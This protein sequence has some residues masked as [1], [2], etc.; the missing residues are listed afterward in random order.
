LLPNQE[1]VSGAWLIHHSSK[2]QNVSTSIEYENI[3]A[4]GKSATLLSALSAESEIT[5]PH[6]RVRTLAVAARISSLELPSILGIL[7]KRSLID[8]GSEEI[9]V[10]GLTTRAT[11]SHASDIFESRT[12]NNIERASLLLAEISSHSPVD[13][14]SIAERLGDEFSLSAYEVGQ[15]LNDAEQIG[16]VDVE[17]LDNQEQLYF[18]G[19]LFRRESISKA[20][21]V[22]DSLTRAEEVAVQEL[23]QE[24]QATACLSLDRVTTV[25]GDNLFGKVFAIGLFDMNTVCNS[26]E[27]VAFIT[28]PSSF[29]KYSSSM[30]DDAFDLAKA[31]VC[32]I[33]YGMT[34]S[35]HVRGRISMVSRLLEVLIR[36]QEVGPVQAIA[37]DY[38]LLELKGVVSVRIGSRNGRH[39]PILRLLKPEV[40]ELALQVIQ[41][42]DASEHSLLSLPTAKVTSFRGPEHN[43]EIIRKKQRELN[44][45]VTNDML[46]ALRRGRIF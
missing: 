38:R 44:P 7:E 43:R 12:P 10:L 30:I 39:G 11:L 1:E 34:Q 36:G 9:S 31:F 41:T 21:S 5:I 25:L 37:E 26:S 29:S 22:L 24:L 17:S 35:T 46:S 28:L 14:R 13:K 6:S 23:M 20:K 4:A 42:G 15:A 27:S 19:N 16:F 33:T 8:Q 2:L 18:N 45:K 3:T 32:S 40:G